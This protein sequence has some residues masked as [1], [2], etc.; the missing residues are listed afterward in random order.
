MSEIVNTEAVGAS[1][2]E[3]KPLLLRKDQSEN[4]LIRLDISN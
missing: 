2:N 1:N 3:I 4:D